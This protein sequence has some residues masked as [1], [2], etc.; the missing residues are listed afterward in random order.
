MSTGIARQ[1]NEALGNFNAASDH[2]K[3]I[4]PDT[5]IDNYAIVFEFDQK[6]SKKKSKKEKISAD[7]NRFYDDSMD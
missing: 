5:G 1:F 2:L 7:V 3:E 4:C 6:L